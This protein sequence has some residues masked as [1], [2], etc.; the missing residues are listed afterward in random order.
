MNILLKIVSLLFRIEVNFGIIINNVMMILINLIKNYQLY[1]NHLI[2]FTLPHKAIYQ[3]FRLFA[4]KFFI[5]N[6]PYCAII[7]IDEDN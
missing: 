4:T 7:I 5:I 6:H 3:K 2:C 1:L